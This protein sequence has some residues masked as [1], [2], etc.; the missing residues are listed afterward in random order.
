[1][2]GSA[3]LLGILIVST[4]AAFPQDALPCDCAGE[5]AAATVCLTDTQMSAQAKHIEMQ[6]DRVGNHVNVKGIVIMELIVGKNGRVLNAK[7][8]S[9][10]PVQEQFTFRN[11]IA[12]TGK[13]RIQ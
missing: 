8:I 10:H 3:F 11:E 9:G 6:P 13:S 4:P 5:R 2:N 12:L 1:M 7:A